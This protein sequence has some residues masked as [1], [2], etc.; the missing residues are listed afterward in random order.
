MPIVLLLFPLHLTKQITTTVSTD[1]TT[2]IF[3]E[4]D[5]TNTTCVYAD[6]HTQNSPLPDT[7]PPPTHV[8]PV[9]DTPSPTTSTPMMVDDFHGMKWYNSKDI[10]DLY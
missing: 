1:P 3:P 9:P 6:P 4:S 10:I 7:T 2:P 5:T 8:A